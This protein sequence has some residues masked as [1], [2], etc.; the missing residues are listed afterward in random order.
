VGFEVAFVEVVGQPFIG[1]S[2][3]EDTVEIGR[4]G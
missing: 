2:L 1:V 3:A 4:P